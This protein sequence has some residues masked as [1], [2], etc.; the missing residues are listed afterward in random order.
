MSKQLTMY[1][2]MSFILMR[3]GDN[4][5]TAPIQIRIDLDIKKQATELFSSLGLDMSSAV[6]LL[7]WIHCVRARNWMRSIET[8]D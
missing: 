5:A 4:M 7:L 8:M 2:D 1:T 3:G 6:N